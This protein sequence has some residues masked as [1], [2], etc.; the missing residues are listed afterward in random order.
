MEV[1]KAWVRRNQEFIHSLESLANVN[2][3]SFLPLISIS[4]SESFFSVNP[5]VV[6]LNDLS[7]ASHGSSR[8]ASPTPRS[9]RKQVL[10]L[11]GN[12]FV[13]SYLLAISLFFFDFKCF[14]V[15]S[16]SV[17]ASGHCRRCQSVYHRHC[18]VPD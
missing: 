15:F 3:F 18:S 17:C 1:Y 12:L 14:W 9:A 10:L 2:P 7:R 16:Y 5:N 13:F 8:S 11:L 6:L 4:I